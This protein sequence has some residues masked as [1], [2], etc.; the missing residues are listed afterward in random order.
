MRL[1]TTRSKTS[2]LHSPRVVRA[3]SLKA[4]QLHLLD[5]VNLLWLL[6]TAEYCRVMR[7]EQHGDRV[8]PLGCVDSV[9]PTQIT[10]AA[11]LTKKLPVILC[12]FPRKNCLIL[13]CYF[14]VMLVVKHLLPKQVRHEFNP[15]VGKSGNPL[16]YSCLENP[17]EKGAW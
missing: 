12:H 13:Q 16:Q 11:A 3:T 15:W 7:R 17:M 9:N 4:H 14:Q 5:T 10:R 1:C 8:S 2:L 6:H